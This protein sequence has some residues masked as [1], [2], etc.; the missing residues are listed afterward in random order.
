LSEIRNTI[1]AA[2]GQRIVLLKDIAD[3]TI[4]EG[5]ILW[6]GGDKKKKSL[7][8]GAKL[9][10]GYNILDVDAAA[11]A[12]IEEFRNKLP[13]TVSLDATFEQA[14]AVE[15]TINSFFINLIQGVAL[16]GVIILLFLGWRSAI[17]IVTLI[18]LC[19]I[20]AMAML[21]GAGYGLQQISIASLVLALGLL[22]DNGIVVIENIHRQ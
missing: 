7:F 22:V 4:R 18:P 15:K 20:L 5:D 1:I 10:N 6:Q 14:V 12:V 2:D 8:V 3:V 9:K 13:V 17:I 16:V 11:N 19:I 21:N